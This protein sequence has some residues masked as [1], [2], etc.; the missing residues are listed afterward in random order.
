MLRRNRV[1]NREHLILR[2]STK[3]SGTLKI[4]SVFF[5]F[6]S[7]SA[8]GDAFH[9]QRGLISHGQKEQL[10]KKLSVFYRRIQT[11]IWPLRLLM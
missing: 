7:L 8:V 10:A 6:V 4:P 11:A 5:G 2:K 9:K 1:N 3:L